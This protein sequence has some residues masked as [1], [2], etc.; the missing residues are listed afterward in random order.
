MFALHHWTGFAVRAAVEIAF[1]GDATP[2]ARGGNQKR[3]RL[4]VRVDCKGEGRGVFAR[5]LATIPFKS[6][7]R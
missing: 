6:S 7:R 2:A 5:A 1:A 3:R 4:S